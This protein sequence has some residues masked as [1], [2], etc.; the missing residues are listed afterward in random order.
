MKPTKADV[1]RI[2]GGINRSKKKYLSL[3]ALSRLVGLY[4]DVLADTLSYFE[5][6]IRLDPT[7]NMRDLVPAMKEFLV[8]PM[9]PV[10]ANKPKRVVVSKKELG[11]YASIGDFVLKKMTNVGG[12][13]EPSTRL[14]DYDLL[15]L[16]KLVSN[17]IAKRKKAEK[18][19]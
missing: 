10:V 4:P 3:E 19:K 1:K 2:L 14:S 17:E 11:Q 5:P 18:K 13:V 15:V 7:I 6:V 8:E 9:K 16:E 12:L